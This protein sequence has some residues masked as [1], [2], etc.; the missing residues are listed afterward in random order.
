MSDEKLAP[1]LHFAQNYY[2][3][4][5]FA[6]NA[7]HGARVVCLAKRIHSREGGDG[8]LVEAGAW[9]HQLHDDLDALEAFLGS[10]DLKARQTEKL[11]EIVR[12]CRP[13]RI[14]PSSSLEAKIVFD[15]DALEVLGPYGTVRELLCNAVARGMSWQTSVASTRD[16]QQRFASRLMTSTARSLVAEALPITERFWNVYDEW[17]AGYG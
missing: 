9:L 7:S 14:G 10:L 16:V 2:Q 13:D 5:D 8:F 11:F 17:C 3:R 15:A 1:I 6:H 12:C 4:L